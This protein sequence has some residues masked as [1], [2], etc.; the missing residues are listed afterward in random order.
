MAVLKLN[1]TYT[2]K[3]LADKN[4]AVPVSQ[5]A[6][7]GMMLLNETG[8]LLWTALEKGADKH[9]LQ[10]LLLREY[11]VTR[12]MA[13]ADVEEFLSRLRKIGALDP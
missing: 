4:I 9:S 12:E 3:K 5:T 10:Q 2:V 13:M 7:S 6:G 11:D 8:F 1:Q